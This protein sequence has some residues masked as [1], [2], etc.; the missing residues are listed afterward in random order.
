MKKYIMLVFILTIGV[1]NIVGCGRAEPD[2]EISA[3]KISD[4]ITKV[5]VVHMD[6]GGIIQWVAEGSEID[7]LRNWVNGLE[8]ALFEYEEGKSPGDGEGGEVYRFTYDEGSDLEF[9]YVINGPDKCYL[10]IEDCWY[11][12]KNPSRPPISNE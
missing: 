11:V 2:S 12:V 6:C 5:N 7:E 4:D 3:L 10:L 8:Y 1:C 9:S